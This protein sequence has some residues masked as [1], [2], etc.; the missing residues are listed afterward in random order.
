M[1][2]GDL[3]PAEQPP[4]AEDG[5]GLI[6]RFWN[7]SETACEARVMFWKRPSSVSRCNLGERVLGTLG[8]DAAGRVAVPARGREIVTLMARF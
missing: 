5:N 2:L 3:V 4:E 1:G 6:V 7:T 8:L